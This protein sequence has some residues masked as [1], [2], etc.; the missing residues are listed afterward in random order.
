MTRHHSPRPARR[1]SR[2]EWIRHLQDLRASGLD[3]PAFARSRG[4][5]P[6]SLRWWSWRLRRELEPA[7]RPVELVARATVVE[8]DD[9]VEVVIGE[10][11]VRIRRGTPSTIAALVRELRATC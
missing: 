7:S 1:R 9:L 5:E 3:L 8:L 2:E 4:L 11:V 6:K 10:V